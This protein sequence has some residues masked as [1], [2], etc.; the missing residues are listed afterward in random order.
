MAVHG[1]CIMR[2]PALSSLRLT[3][4]NI[5][6]EAVYWLTQASWPQLM[7]LD[8][9]YSQL[10]AADVTLTVSTLWPKLRSLSLEGCPFGHCGL[11]QLIK[12]VWPLTTLRIG[13]D[14]RE[15]LDGGLLLGLD[16]DKVQELHT[17][18]L[19]A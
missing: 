16:P 4:G 8:L 2:L 1:L 10:D 5:A 12:G 15:R 14:T 11:Q 7:S 13:F 6:A 17:S 18:L 3:T 19:R 9:S